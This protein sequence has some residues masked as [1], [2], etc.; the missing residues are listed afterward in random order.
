MNIVVPAAGLGA[1]FRNS[2][3]SNVPKP[4]INIHGKTMIQ[5]VIENFNLDGCYYFIV[6]EEHI[7]T[8]DIDKHLRN[9]VPDCRIIPVVGRTQGPMCSILKAEIFINCSDP[10]LT[11]NCDQIFSW[12]PLHFIECVKSVDGAIM[13]FECNEPHHSYVEI[14]SNGF[15]I[16]LAEKKVISNRASN[17]VYYWN[18]GSY[19]VACAKEAIRLEH[20]ADNGEFYVSLAYNELIKMGGIVI[21]YPIA[22]NRHLGTPQELD[23]YLKDN[24]ETDS[25]QRQHKRA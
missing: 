16:Q 17:G 14:D 3:Y 13:T 15:V 20:R 19:F 10:L 12:N 1:R 25:T 5:A 8:Y 18:C 21:E 22:W 6:N 9:L 7:K 11:L 2:E 4:L 24:N 23:T